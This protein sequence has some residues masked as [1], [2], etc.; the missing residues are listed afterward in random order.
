M[1]SSISYSKIESRNLVSQKS[2]K[3]SKFSKRD[4]LPYCYTEN[5][6]KE[7][8]VLEHVQDY[9]RQFR[10]VF[11]E[12]AQRQLLLYPKNECG[13]EKFICTTMRPTQLPFLELYDWAH[14]AEFIANFLEYEELNPPDQFPEIIPAPCNV[15][16]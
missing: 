9:E 15:L 16:S 2:V 14:S 12:H 5:S 1:D 10:L 7:S 6:Q 3:C 11:R 13:T 8:L 4:D